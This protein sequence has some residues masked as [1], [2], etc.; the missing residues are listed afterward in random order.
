[1]T[2][3]VHHVFFIFIKVYILYIFCY[4][5]YFGTQ[6]FIS[7]QRLGRVHVDPCSWFHVM[8]KTGYDVRDQMIE[9]YWEVCECGWRRAIP[10]FVEHNN[11]RKRC[12]ISAQISD[13]QQ[14]LSLTWTV[15]L[16][17]Q[18]R[19]TLAAF[20][21][22]LLSGPRTVCKYMSVQT[23]WRWPWTLTEGKKVKGSR[24]AVPVFFFVL[25]M[26]HTLN[27]FV[28]LLFALC[29]HW[30]LVAQKGLPVFLH[31][32]WRCSLTVLQPACRV[33]LSFPCRQPCVLFL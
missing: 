22:K 31:V 23:C 1:M 19:D 2:S 27:L 5:R 30:E 10:I 16:A 4:L 11:L 18:Q 28:G 26:H 17:S 3:Y 32:W 33:S 12:L 7:W 9:S 14:T 24:S 13:H 6:I 15:T 21:C 25:R 29:C 8:L 20:L